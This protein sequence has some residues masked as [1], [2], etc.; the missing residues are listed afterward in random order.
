M[1]SSVEISLLKKE[2]R[3][4]VRYQFQTMAGSRR[5]EDGWALVQALAPDLTVQLQNHTGV[6]VWGCSCLKQ[7]VICNIKGAT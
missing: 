2:G 1:S 6:L 7:L 3:K 5:V 4:S